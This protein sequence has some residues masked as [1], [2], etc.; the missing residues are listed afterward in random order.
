MRAK[1]YYLNDES[2]RVVVKVMD[3]SF[4]HVTGK[5]ELMYALQAG[6]GR[7]FELDIPEESILFVKKWNDMV[8]ISYVYSPV[9]VRSDGDLLYWGSL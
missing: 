1:I 6:E 8:M 9:H 2:K 3:S 7:T 5:G 4:D